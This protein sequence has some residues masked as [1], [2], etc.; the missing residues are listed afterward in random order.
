MTV[1]KHWCCFICE[2]VDSKLKRDSGLAI[3]SLLCGDVCFRTPWLP[4]QAAGQLKRDLARGTLYIAIS[5]ILLLCFCYSVD[6]LC[7]HGYSRHA[8]ANSVKEID[9][10]QRIQRRSEYLRRDAFINLIWFSADLMTF[11]PLA[12]GTTKFD[13]PRSFRSYLDIYMPTRVLYTT[14]TESK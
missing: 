12:L 8:I 2:T 13:L 7:I 9:R 5:F 1:I 4:A 11:S 3:A 10:K 6:S 14:F